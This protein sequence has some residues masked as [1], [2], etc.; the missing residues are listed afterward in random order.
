MEQLTIL[1][2]ETGLS[3]LWSREREGSGLGVWSF[4]C[5]LFIKRRTSSCLSAEEA[6][7]HPVYE[8]SFPWAHLS[9]LVLWL[10]VSLWLSPR[11]PLC[12]PCIICAV[13][14]KLFKWSLGMVLNTFRAISQ[15]LHLLIPASAISHQWGCAHMWGAAARDG[16]GPHCTKRSRW[17]E[18]GAF[19][20]TPVWLLG[21][22][23]R[24]SSSREGQSP[25][26]GHSHQGCHRLSGRFK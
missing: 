5:Q 3:Q 19:V 2:R 6:I 18:K 17:G 22:G 24:G 21:P 11:L 20:P 23:K 25:G 14:V 12:L 7:H 1:Q 16:A 13:C 4:F 26:C 9:R 8:R 15:N 10:L